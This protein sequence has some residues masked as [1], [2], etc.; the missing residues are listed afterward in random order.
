MPEGYY[1]LEPIEKLAY[2]IWIFSTVLLLLNVII[3]EIYLYFN[4][5]IVDTLPMFRREGNRLIR[6]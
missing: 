5:E 4:P 2:F 3:N 6:I 1:F